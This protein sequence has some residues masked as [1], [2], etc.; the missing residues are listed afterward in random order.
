MKMWGLILLLF[1]FPAGWSPSLAISQNANQDENAP[2]ESQCGQIVVRG[3]EHLTQAELCRFLEL[4]L[5]TLS[6][7]QARDSVAA[8]IIKE[9]NRRGFLDA[10]L[11]WKGAEDS[12]NPASVTPV[13]LIVTEGP[14]YRLRRLEFIGNST[15][16]DNVIRRRV[17]F[18]PNDAFDEE[19]LELSIKRINELGLFYEFKR[20][21]VEVKA[22]KKGKFVDLV[23]NLKER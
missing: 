17:A 23:F 8:K 7:S 14:V 22:N 5:D 9:Y 13:L 6:N 1:M 4:D 21:D 16:R 19:L 20:E 2:S 12:A 15:T 18:N 10:V 11:S 3:S